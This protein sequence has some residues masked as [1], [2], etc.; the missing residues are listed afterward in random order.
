MNNISITIPGFI[1]LLIAIVLIIFSSKK[2]I[3]MIFIFTACF[4]TYNQLIIAAGFHFTIIRLLIFVT[5]I[6]FIVRREIDIFAMNTIDK[7][8]LLWAIVATIT[9]TLLWSSFE[10][11][12]YKLGL[13]YDAIG[14]YFMFRI[15][16]KEYKDMELIYKTLIISIIPV[17]LFMLY[18]KYKGINLYFYFSGAN[19]F[20]E[21]RNGRIRCQGPFRHSILAG[22]YGATSLPLFVALYSSK[23]INRPLFIIGLT[24]S[25]IIIYASASSGPIVSLLLSII[26]FGF[27]LF[28]DRMKFVMWCLLLSILTLHIFMKAPVWFIFDRISGLMGGSGWHRSYL[29]DQAITHFNDWWLI[30]AKYTAD[31]FP[32]ALAVDP[33]KADITNAYIGHGVNGGLVTMILFILIIIQC[34]RGLGNAQKINVSHPL[35]ARFCLWAIGV[36]LF[37]HVVSFLSITYFDQMMVFW[38]LIIAI[39]STIVDI[40]NINNEIINNNS[41]LAFP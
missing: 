17:A 4:L 30:G 25:L 15:T 12:K 38:Y 5:W 26:A 14:L 11:F 27:W 19:P 37:T 18:E 1:F 13:F 34:F 31:W 7:A 9:Y 8:L 41:D 35:G 21:I 40:N 32:Y 24:S 36:C 6:R 22:T 39:T 20:S 2:Y 3:P 23:I 10:A 29:I 33:N 28:R 16:I